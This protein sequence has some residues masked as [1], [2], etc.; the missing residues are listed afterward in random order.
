MF[1]FAPLLALPQHAQRKLLARHARDDFVRT[2]TLSSAPPVS[3]E[4]AG[5]FVDTCNVS[6]TVRRDGCFRDDGVKP[7]LAEKILFAAGGV[8]VT[9]ILAMLEAL[10]RSGFGDGLDVVV[11]FSVRGEDAV[12]AETIS[13]NPVVSRLV[14]FD[15]KAGERRTSMIESSKVEFNARRVVEAD[16]AGVAE[17][18]ERE[19]F[20]CGPLDFMKAVKVW[21]CGLGV[22]ES[23]MHDESF[24]F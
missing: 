23:R 6:C 22:D 7:L 17:L 13:R 4:I 3:H 11:L 18:N 9:P 21:L 14:L 15:S 16:V 5:T 1:D 10:G 24:A 2:W 19:C 20:V 12:L 8:G